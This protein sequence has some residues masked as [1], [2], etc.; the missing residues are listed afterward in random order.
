MDLILIAL[1]VLSSD[2]YHQ[3]LVQNLYQQYLERGADASGLS[4]GI[5][6]ALATAFLHAAGAGL[7]FCLARIGAKRG[8]AVLRGAGGA[9]AVC[10]LAILAGL[11]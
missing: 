3:K 11:V 8:D 10:G 9:A 7:G 6:F 4:Y 1:A 5:G 2:E